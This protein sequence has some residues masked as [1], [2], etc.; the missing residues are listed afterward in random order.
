MKIEDIKNLS[1]AEDHAIKQYGVLYRSMT[2]DIRT[3]Y[4]YPEA[5]IMFI[6]LFESIVDTVIDSNQPKESEDEFKFLKEQITKIYDS[7]ENR[8][9]FQ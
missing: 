6:K 7:F 5:A 3:E 2:K 8:K 1:N 9:V 4:F